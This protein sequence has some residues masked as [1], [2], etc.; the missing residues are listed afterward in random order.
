MV[1]KVLPTDTG[2]QLHF[3]FSILE[4]PKEGNGAMSNSNLKIH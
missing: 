1:I 2:R 4:K 3:F